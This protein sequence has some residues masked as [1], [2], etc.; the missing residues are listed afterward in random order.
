MPIRA[1]FLSLIVLLT[2]CDRGPKGSYGFALPDGDPAAGEQIFTQLACTDCHLIAE[3]PELREGLENP[4]LSIPLGGETTRIQ[5][6][7]ELVT[8]VIN[9]S[10]KISQRYI[11]AP[12]IEDGESVMQNYNDVLT[13][14]ELIDLVAFLQDQYSLRETPISDYPYYHYP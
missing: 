4:T 14:S 12:L 11:S 1:L 3:R 7:G 5:T 2:A 10:H 9:P 8:S 6:Y 13:V